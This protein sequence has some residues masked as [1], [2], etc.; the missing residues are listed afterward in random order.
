MYD[1]LLDLEM[2]VQNTDVSSV[3]CTVLFFLLRWRYVMSFWMIRWGMVYPLQREDAVVSD[4]I[5][6]VYIRKWTCVWE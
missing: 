2:F 5:G 1:S 6:F 4:V 3:G